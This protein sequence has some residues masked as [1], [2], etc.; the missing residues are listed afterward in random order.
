MYEKPQTG[1]DAG[2]TGSA[3]IKSMCDVSKTNLRNGF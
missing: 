1:A 2:A 3:R